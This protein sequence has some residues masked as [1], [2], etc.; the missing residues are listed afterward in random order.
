LLVFIGGGAGALLRWG[1]GRAVGGPTAT[2]LANVIGCLL[3]GLLT[4]WLMGRAQGESWR[5]LLG[6][7]LLGG[8]TTFSAF[9]LDFALLWRDQPWAALGYSAGS[10]FLSLAAVFAGLALSR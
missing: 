10:V 9:A 1:V 2:L 6:V 8:F 7:G 3:M 5:L 4:G